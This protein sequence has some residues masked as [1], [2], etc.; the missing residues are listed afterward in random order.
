MRSDWELPLQPPRTPEG[1]VGP[2][3]EA[4]LRPKGL[5]LSQSLDG[6]GLG[7]LLSRGVS[8]PSSLPGQSLSLTLLSP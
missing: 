7:V 8:V 2:V 4:G 6:A 1:L 5:S 3:E